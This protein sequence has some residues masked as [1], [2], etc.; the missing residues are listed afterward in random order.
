MNELLRQLLNQLERIGHDHGELYDSV[1]RER[2]S[3]AV[4]DGFIRPQAGFSV[5]GDF[6]LHSREA[7][8]A[9]GKA[10][11]TFIEHANRHAADVGM[12]SFEQRLAAFQNGDI[13]SEVEG[14]YY[15][16]FFGH[17]DPQ[18]FDAGGGEFGKSKL[19]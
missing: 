17:S 1:C 3:D 13:M 4:F 19:E 9:V 14:N 10:L 6:G 7:N 12:S 15:D 5:P 11:S 16:D 18:S 2:M 8:D